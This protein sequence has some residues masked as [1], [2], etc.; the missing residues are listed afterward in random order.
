[1][2]TWAVSLALKILQ[3]CH[4]HCKGQL[5]ISFD[6]RC[7]CTC[8]LSH[9]YISAAHTYSCTGPGSRRSQHQHSDA[10]Q[11]ISLACPNAVPDGQGSTRQ[12]GQAPFQGHREASRA[13]RTTWTS[14]G[15]IRLCLWPCSD[16]LSNACQCAWAEPMSLK[17]STLGHCSGSH[18][19]TANSCAGHADAHLQAPWTASSAGAAAPAGCRHASPGALAG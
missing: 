6:P 18:A 1:M 19:P 8:R 11:H 13:S 2:L 15:G 12:H 14:P 9:D 7:C 10:Q 3:Q 16:W 17:T 4:H 5:A